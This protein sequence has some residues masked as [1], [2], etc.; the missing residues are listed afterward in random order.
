MRF[1]NSESE[2]IQTKIKNAL[3]L[4]LSPW[5]GNL[6]PVLRDHS[7]TTEPSQALGNVLP[8]PLREGRGEG[9]FIFV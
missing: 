5:R 1:T 3:T 2:L 6:E 4:T 7:L 8:L 9:L